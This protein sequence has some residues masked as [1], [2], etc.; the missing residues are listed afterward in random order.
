MKHKNRVTKKR[1]YW[2]NALRWFIIILAFFSSRLPCKL[3]ISAYNNS[4]STLIWRV[5]KANIS[6]IGASPVCKISHAQT[7]NSFCN[8]A[9]NK[10]K[11]LSAYK[12][13]WKTFLT[14]TRIN[15]LF[16]KFIPILLIFRYS[17][18][19]SIHMLI[20]IPICCCT[21]FRKITKSLFYSKA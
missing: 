17:S 15:K 18:K 13:C 19:N 20:S 7:V 2:W 1:L 8:T 10:R 4:K 21:A 5:E 16:L 3:S 12:I 6:K 11:Y 14:K 9:L